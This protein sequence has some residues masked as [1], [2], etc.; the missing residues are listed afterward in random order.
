MLTSASQPVV[1]D[2]Q[3]TSMVELKAAAAKPL[4]DQRDEL[5]GAGVFN[6]ASHKG[7]KTA[8]KGVLIKE[9][10]KNRINVTSLQTVAP[11][12]F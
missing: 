8:V 5:L 10:Q 6:P 12:C 2:A 4:G 11:T 7:Q 3:P 1:S 9:N